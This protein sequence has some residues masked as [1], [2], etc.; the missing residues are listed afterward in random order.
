MNSLQ[1]IWLSTSSF[2]FI[3]IYENEHRRLQ[4]SGPSWVTFVVIIGLIFIMYRL[5][6]FLQYLSDQWKQKMK[7]RIDKALLAR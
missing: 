1:E 6:K 7:E 5:M 4:Q 2:S 3:T